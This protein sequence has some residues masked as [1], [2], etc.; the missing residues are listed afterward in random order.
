MEAIIKTFDWKE[1][2]DAACWAVAMELS[3]YDVYQI[4]KGCDTY[5]LLAGKATYVGGRKEADGKR[6]CDMKWLQRYFFPTDPMKRIKGGLIIEKQTLL[7]SSTGRV[8]ESMYPEGMADSGRIERSHKMENAWEKSLD[9]KKSV[10]ADKI[11]ETVNGDLVRVISTK[12]PHMHYPAIGVFISNRK[13]NDITCWS[14][15]GTKCYE[16]KKEDQLILDEKEIN[17]SGS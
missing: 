17:P 14:L 6:F 13:I 15:D 10:E 9:S 4:D 5:W 7:K 1:T 12:G 11:Y 2:A 3:D 16:G 8:D